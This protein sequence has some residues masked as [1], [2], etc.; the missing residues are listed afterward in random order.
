MIFYDSPMAK[1][2]L[3]GITNLVDVVHH[4]NYL[5]YDVLE[6]GLL[7]PSSGKT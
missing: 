3:G 2:L 1:L 4:N 7:S 5:K 6:T